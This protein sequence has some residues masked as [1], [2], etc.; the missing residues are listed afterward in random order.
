MT[1][2]LSLAVVRKVGAFH[3]LDGLIEAATTLPPIMTYQTPWAN[4]RMRGPA[5][6][7]RASRPTKRS[8]AGH[9]SAST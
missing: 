5:S 7:T 2:G 3:S 9:A 6:E 1:K 8:W 4:R